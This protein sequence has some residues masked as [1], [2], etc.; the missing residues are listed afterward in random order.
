[1]LFLSLIISIF[2]IGALIYGIVDFFHHWSRYVITEIKE[3]KYE[4]VRSKHKNLSS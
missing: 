2:I 3:R 1:M 4:N